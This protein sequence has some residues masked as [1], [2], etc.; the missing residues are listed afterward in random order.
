[1]STL[2][3]LETR[4]RSIVENILVK[5]VPGGKPEDQV[6]Q[7]LAS[8]LQAQIRSQGG[9]DNLAPNVYKIVAHPNQA[10]RWS[11][12][13]AFLD[14]LAHALEMAGVEANLT[15]SSRITM[16]I[17]A[18]ASMAEE[19]V[20]VFASY[21]TGSISETQGMQSGI[22]LQEP[23]RKIIDNTFLI[24]NGN[25]IIPIDQPMFNLGRRL[26]NHAV[27]DDLRVSRNHAQIRAIKG[28]YLI[29]DLNSS[30]GTFVNGIRINQS[31]LNPGDVISLAGV[32]L[33]FGQDRPETGQEDPATRIT[34]FKSQ[35]HPTEVHEEDEKPAE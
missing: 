32:T 23:A 31:I 8:L 1:M 17:S 11:L 24:K 13:P 18:D 2:G 14:E 19:D 20:Q 27:I 10:D 33:I 5:M 26:D 30:G 21:S 22:E 7:K 29:F 15:F 28:N 12:E 35:D 4:I 34:A 6:S 16:S 9:D 3:N 25:E